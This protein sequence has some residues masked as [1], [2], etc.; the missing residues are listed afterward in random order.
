MKFIDKPKSKKF[1]DIEHQKFNSLK[2]I[3]FAGRI[4]KITYWYCLC[5]C[6]NITKVQAGALK[7]NNTKSCGC[8][9][10]LNM[11]THNLSKIPEYLI[12]NSAK[13]RC[14]NP[15]DGRYKDWG[16]RGIKFRFK[17][18]EEFINH[19]G[20]RPSKEYQLDRI[21]NN[22]H[23]QIGNIQWAVI[24]KQQ[25]NKRNNRWITYNDETKCMEDWAKETGICQATISARINK[26]KWC[27]NCALSIKPNKNTKKAI[28]CQHLNLEN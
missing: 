17:D 5:D 2:V 16:G 13:K 26:Y 4:N 3:G 19:I 28:V 14:N 6:G 9:R 8:L 11:T 15:N 12:Y 1:E 25:R 22:G 18:F 23:Y 24:D 10:V 21:D 27:T 20:F 7:G